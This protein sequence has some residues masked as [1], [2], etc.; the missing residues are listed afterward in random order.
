MV[1]LVVMVAMVVMVV[2]VVMVVIVVVVIVVMVVVVVSVELT[3][4]LTL[5]LKFNRSERSRG[6]VKKTQNM[7][8]L[9][10]LSLTL[11]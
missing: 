2:V 3:R 7:L 11:V 6:F 4:S 8:T 9:Y 10:I 5:L 1:V